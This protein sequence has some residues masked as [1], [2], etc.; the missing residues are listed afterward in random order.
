MR[1]IKRVLIF[2]MLAMLY[3]SYAYAESP[4]FGTNVKVFD[5]SMPLAQIQSEVDAVYNQQVNNEMG[6]Q[7]YALLFKPGVYGSAEQPL[8]I[9]V[10]Y[11]T[12]VAGLGAV[13]T[14]VTINGHV[15]VY[16]RCLAEN[17]CIALDNFWRSL[18]NLSINVSGQ[19]LD[20]CRATSNF[21]AASQAA[22]MRR[23]NINGQLSLM[24]YCTAGPQY[25][26]GGFAADVKVSG[27]VINGSQQQYIVRNSSV[28]SWSNGVWNQVFSGVKGAP[29]QS[30]GPTGSSNQPYTTL[31][32]SPV[33]R[34]KPF[35]YLDNDK[36]YRVYVP[37]V[38]QNS[39]GVTWEAGLSS[40]GR[41][42]PL[43]QFYIAKPTDTAQTISHALMRGYH[44]LLSPGVYRLEQAIRIERP[45]A[46]VLGLGLPTLVPANGNAAMVVGNISNVML[47]GFMVDAGEKKSA[48]LV[49][50]GHAKYREDDRDD[51]FAGV[52][53]ALKSENDM[54]RGSK[55][56]GGHNGYDN[57]PTVLSDIFF[58]IGGSRV[59]QAGTSLIV[60][61]DNVLLDN[62]WAWRAD[63]GNAGTVGWEINK[64]NHGVVIN[65]DDVTAYG[66]FVEHYQKTNVIWRGER[67]RTIFFQN[68][69][70]YDPPNQ[71]SWMDGATKG[72]PAYRVAKYVKNHEAWGLGS[73]AYFNVDA[74]I[75][76]ANSFEVPVTP[77]VR[78]HSMAT[79]S[80]SGQG[81]IDHIVNLTGDTASATTPSP[82]R[83]VNYP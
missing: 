34:E 48:V 74:T 17:N 3:G 40:R 72:Y 32:Q 50:I 58:R 2:I 22:P 31:N 54:V 6:A 11:N 36:N 37:E 1:L 39:S 63:H 10:G 49:Q 43:T 47:A 56:H 61:N 33:T 60:N 13:P 75:H 26:S 78:L 44:L 5:S 68:E 18:S 15:D 77:G 12:E 79:V 29:A 59:G 27:Q 7:H 53:E 16:N 52:G 24:D 67:G 20:G 42:V 69:L 57:S 51:S 73:Y 28:G 66:L 25:A 80:L 82:A 30:Y 71:S 83:M 23:V 9:K 70:P 65:G 14:D 45:G 46:V 55:Q 76:A 8:F 81:T 64:A 19:G 21:W 38:M 62:I 41:S 35:L 4:A